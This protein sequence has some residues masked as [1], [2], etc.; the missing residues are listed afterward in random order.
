MS[1]IDRDKLKACLW[2]ILHEH[3]VE[4]LQVDQLLA[5]VQAELEDGIDCS[6]PRHQNLVLEVAHDELRVIQQ[7]VGAERRRELETVYISWHNHL[8]K[9]RKKAQ[10]SKVDGF[11][12][13]HASDVTRRQEKAQKEP[14][15]NPECEKKFVPMKVAVSGS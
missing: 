1:G 2:V 3:E 13:R 15:V 6:Q 12:E 14:P 8:Q 10:K 4:A 5:T 9:E 7:T 11:L